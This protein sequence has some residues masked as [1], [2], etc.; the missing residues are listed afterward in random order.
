MQ[1]GPQL[2]VDVGATSSTPARSNMRG[3]LRHGLRVATGYRR[4][5]PHG[6]A[7]TTRSPRPVCR[8][9]PGP[10]ISHADVDHRAA[11]PGKARARRHARRRCRRRSA[12][13]RPPRRA[14]GAARSAA[15]AASVSP[16]LTQNSTRSAPASARLGAR[17]DAASAAVSLSVGHLEL[18]AAGTHRLHVFGATD[19]RHGVARAGEHGP[20]EAADGAGA[21]HPHLAESRRGHAFKRSC[22]RG[23]PSTGRAAGACRACRSGG[24]AARPRSRSC[25]GT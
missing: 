6:R 18:Q 20:E 24:A 22:W 19:Q 3:E 2:D 14:R 1:L 25:A 17:L 7:P 15:R 12:G 16:D 21:H 11:A 13:S 8:T 23:P 9:W 4:A 10:V 5:V